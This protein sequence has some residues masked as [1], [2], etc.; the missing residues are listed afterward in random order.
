MPHWQPPPGTTTLVEPIGAA[1]GLDALTATVVEDDRLLL[2]LGAS[3]RP[4]PT[5][6]VVTSFF[7][8]EALVRVTG[9]LIADD[10]EGALYELVVKDV[11]RIQ[12]RRAHRVQI[13]LAATLVVTDGGGPMQSIR[14]RT[15][16]VS[17][18]GCR[19]V[20]DKPLPSG[21]QPMISLDIRDDG[22]P[23][24]AETTVLAIDHEDSWWDYRLMFTAI[25][26]SDRARLDRLGALATR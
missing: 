7:T 25:E 13:E 20:T 14:G 19:V 23:F 11:E 4:G 24:M 26:D 17:V 9:V 16:N 6:D 15:R 5:V 21:A 18:G 2:D 8:P 3:P 10:S 12:R 1:P 22:P